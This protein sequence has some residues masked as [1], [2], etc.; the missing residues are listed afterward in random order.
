MDIVSSTKVGHYL[1]KTIMLVVK[2]ISPNLP[3]MGQNFYHDMLM[4]LHDR[5]PGFMNFRRILD[6]LGLQKQVRRRLSES[7]GAVVFEFSTNL[8]ALEHV[9]VVQI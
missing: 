5:M 7:H 3:Q 1:P 4:P 8:Y 2:S 6:F 9:P